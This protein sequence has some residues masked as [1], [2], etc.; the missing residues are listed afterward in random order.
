MVESS[1][2]K[3]MP[4]SI[5]EKIRTRWIAIDSMAGVGLDP[6]MERIPREIW[7]QVGGKHNY[8][9]GYSLFN[10]RII[11][12]TSPYVVDYK[13]NSSFYQGPEGRKALQFTFDYLKNN[14]PDIVRVCD[15][16][17]ADIGNTA[18]V[19]AREVF[20]NL[21]ADAVL[22]NPYMGFDAIEPFT[23][24]KDKLVI[25]CVNTSNPS[26][27]SIQSLELANGVPLWKHILDISMN[28]WNKNGNI[29][30]VL[31]ATHPANLQGIRDIIGQAPILLA[32]VGSQGG[33]LPQ[34][35]PFCL[36]DS[37]YGIMISSSRGILYP[38]RVEGEDYIEA[39]K[40][41]I[42]KLRNSINEAK[43]NY[44]N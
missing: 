43:R 32:G 34:S 33:D 7:D 17:F 30:P 9:D 20:E 1:E 42:Q 6:D 13:I 39:S 38:P 23:K 5:I 15:G 25:L 16:K 41:E 29:I 24:Y 11:E 19:I 26:A 35:I 3:L 14:Y 36:D 8:G 44:I 22:L 10:Q 12:A 4:N 2:V 28:E 37:D 21:D 18:E 40:R 31:S 27:N